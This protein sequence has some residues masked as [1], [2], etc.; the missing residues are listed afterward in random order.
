M[1]TFLCST[2]EIRMKRAP[3]VKSGNKC[4]INF[5]TT[6]LPLGHIWLVH[7]TVP[8]LYHVTKNK[9]ERSFTYKLGHSMFPL[10]KDKRF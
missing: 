6:N 8:F 3:S 7:V 10:E 5:L 1:G 9:Y 4:R 2:V